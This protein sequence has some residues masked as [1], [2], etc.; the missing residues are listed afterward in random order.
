MRPIIPPAVPMSRPLS[1]C[2]SN[3]ESPDIS[4]M[5]KFSMPF[6][7]DEVVA[8]LACEQLSPGVACHKRSYLL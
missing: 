7:S 4:D 6:I 1:C 5:I 8:L 3:D 2:V